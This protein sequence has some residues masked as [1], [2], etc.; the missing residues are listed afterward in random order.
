MAKYC[1]ARY[2]DT[3]YCGII[4]LTIKEF[5]APE[6]VDLYTYESEVEIEGAI[7]GNLST[8]DQLV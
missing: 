8:R 5:K 2:S 7:I 6:D 4:Q 1:S 3:V